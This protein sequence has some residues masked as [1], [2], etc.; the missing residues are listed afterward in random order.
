MLGDFYRRIYKKDFTYNLKP[1]LIV[2][3]KRCTLVSLVG[4]ERITIDYCL[5]FDP[6]TG[7]S[8]NIGNDFIIVETKSE[9]GKG[10][11]DVMLKKFGIRQ[12]SKLSKYCV[13]AILTGRVTKYNN[14]RASLKRV[15][16]NIVN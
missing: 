7:V 8:V 2:N 9:D 6:I 16:A 10:A 3:Y 4:G 11:A 12:A 14:F 13:G 5:G 15:V 1:A